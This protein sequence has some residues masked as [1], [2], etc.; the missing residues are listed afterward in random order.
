M[1]RICIF[2][3]SITSD[4]LYLGYDNW[5]TKLRK[6]IGKDGKNSIINLGIVGETTK[7][8]IERIDVESKA[9][10]PDIIIIKIGE[11]DSR[12]NNMTEYSVETSITNFENNIHK[13]INICR[14]YTQ[15]I[16]FIGNLP[17]NESKT[18]PTIW[19]DTE[20]FTNKS[21]KKYDK[22][23]K[24]VCEKKRIFFLELFDNWIKKDYKKLLDKKDG[25]HPNAKGYE[26]IF[27]SVK[28]FLIKN[29][30]I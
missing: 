23:I 22:I 26:E 18:M 14:K 9:R 8:L 28:N 24:S 27:K 15:K 25:L 4:E 20:Y 13:I 2:G 29:K 19:S 30:I 12:F 5:V 6:Y 3:D 17:T 16:I 21:L 10:E 7:G 11:N 1:A